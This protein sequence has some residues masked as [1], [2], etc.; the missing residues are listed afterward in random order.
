MMYISIEVSKV[1]TG[2]D[3]SAALLESELLSRRSDLL[4]EGMG[5]FVMDD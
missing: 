1:V 3:V 2:A 5:I 4:Y